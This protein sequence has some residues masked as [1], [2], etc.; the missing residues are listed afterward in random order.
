M[1]FITTPTEIRAYAEKIKGSMRG[2]EYVFAVGCAQLDANTLAQWKEFNLGWRKW[3]VANGD[4]SIFLSPLALNNIGGQLTAYETELA[5]W[6]EIA[7]TV[8]GSK[9][10]VIVPSEPKLGALG[11]TFEIGAAVTALVVLVLA[12]ALV[13]R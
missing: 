11:A 12:I 13:K 2:L 5:K 6:Q 3:Y 7:N 4:P 1:A 8:C 10:P 9:A